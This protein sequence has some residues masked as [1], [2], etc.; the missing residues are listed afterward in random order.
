VF[1][2]RLASLIGFIDP[3]PPCSAR[4]VQAKA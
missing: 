3:S 4:Q 2:G 1:S